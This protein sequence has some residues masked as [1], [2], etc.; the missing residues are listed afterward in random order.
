LTLD[1]KFGNHKILAVGGV[2]SV[3]YD[4]ARN[5]FGARGDYFS[6]AFAFRTVSN[7]ASILNA[8]SGFATP[9]T[10]FSTFLRADYN[11]SERYY[12]S[13]TI[14]RDGSSRFGEDV[15]HGI[16]PSVS[17]GVRVSDFLTDVGFIS[18]LKIRGGYGRMGNQL[19]VSPQNQFSLFGGAA[20]DSNYDLTGAGTSSLQG[21]RP[22]RLGN[23][24]TQ[25][26]TQITTNIG[27]DANLFNDKLQMSFDWYKKEAED[28]L[29]VVPNPAVYGAASPPAVNI[30]NM[31][32]TGIDLLIDYRDKI[33]SD[34]SF[35]TILTFTTYN[36]EITKYAD[37]ID[38]VSS[39]FGGSRIGNFNRNEVGNAVGMFYG[40]DVLGLFQD[41][42]DV[43]GHAT[44]DGAEPG[45]FKFADTDGDGTITP[46]D[47]I[48][49][50]DPNPDFTYGLNLGL[51]YKDWN[52]SAFFY[53]SQG[54]DIFNYNRWWTD[55]W[56]SFQGQKSQD[57]LNNSWTPTNTS[58]TTPKAS[59]KSNFS[60][61]TQSTSYYIE[62][63][64]F[65]RLRVLRL[66]YTFPTG[67][68]D[69]I[70]IGGLSAYVQ[71]TNLFTA[72][73]YSG[74]DPD[75]NNG[76]DLAFG[77]DLGNYPLT[78]QF[79]FGLSVRF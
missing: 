39:A 76:P 52:I 43:D 22:T 19:P 21:F 8:T 65:L 64:S 4:I 45:F 2:E 44:Q 16:F 57:L 23:K 48:F 47:R 34:L 27:F 46:D 31:Q 73:D 38:F 56:P 15:R 37:D 42:A 3:K 77:V 33:T 12:L 51:T 5:V 36:N 1:K 55:F 17:A 18:D 53:G 72:T 28:L 69:K 24:D 20:S 10:L 14:R 75:L 62:D 30:G 68:L 32:N 13:A 7:G 67:V 35:E 26:E 70:G 61:N 60:T 25:W 41:Q 71:G 79:I 49:I 74:L 9:T 59:N 50:G 78:K 11:F 63:G 66:G 54:N 29:V 58:A 40:Y 6:E